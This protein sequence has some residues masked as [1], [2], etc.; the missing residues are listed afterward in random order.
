MAKNKQDALTAYRDKEQSFV[1]TYI[2]VIAVAAVL[3]LVSRA[4]TLGE[5]GFHDFEL[6]LNV[7]YVVVLGPV[8][9][10][11]LGLW[12]LWVSGQLVEMRRGLGAT[13]A[14]HRGW[15]RL[16]LFLY[17]IPGAACVFLF[18]QFLFETTEPGTDC[19]QF[20]HFRLLW[21]TSLLKVNGWQF[22]YCFGVKPEEQARMPYIFPPIQTWAYLVISLIAMWLGLLVWRNMTSETEI[23]PRLENQ[24]SDSRDRRLPAVDDSLRQTDNEM[25][26]V[27]QNLLWLLPLFQFCVYLGMYVCFRA[28]LVIMG[29]NSLPVLFKVHTIWA[30]VIFAIIMMVLSCAAFMFDSRS[31]FSM[32]Y[33]RLWQKFV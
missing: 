28:I 32:T 29:V 16:F 13:T 4:P 5:V 22:A 23:A 21:D 30:G 20:D 18:R 15:G 1:N 17:L 33:D 2:V 26:W 3:C 10:L 6:K 9:L 31:R 12:R 8:I 19:P 24:Q 27:K 25:V 11:G 7:G 14:K